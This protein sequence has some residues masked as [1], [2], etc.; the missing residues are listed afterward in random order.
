MAK[1][2]TPQTQTP[3]TQD[4]SVQLV[5]MVRSADDYPEPH[6]AEVH[7]DEVANYAEGGWVIVD[8]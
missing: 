7:P 5:R 3:Q 2:Q 8:E 6:E 4:P 1:T